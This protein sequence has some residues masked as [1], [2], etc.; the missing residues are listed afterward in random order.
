MIKA[1]NAHRTL[2]R[3]R[4]YFCRKGKTENIENNLFKIL[5]N[6]ST[7]KVPFKWIPGFSTFSNLTNYINL[8]KIVKGHIKK[9]K[10]IYKIKPRIKRDNS[11]KSYMHIAPSV[12]KS[13]KTSKNFTFRLEKELKL[14]QKTVLKRSTD[15][16]KSEPV[17]FEKRDFLHKIAYTVIPKKWKKKVKKKKKRTKFV[18]KKLKILKKKY[19]KFIYFKKIFDHKFL[20]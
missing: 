4:G 7:K 16:T 8:K 5:I 12:T 6:N 11:Q 20:T 14:L 1:Q 19:K 3:I 2:S 15:L 13:T 17:F 9:K 18:L 10:T